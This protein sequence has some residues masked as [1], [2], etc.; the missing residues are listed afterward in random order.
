MKDDSDDL[1]LVDDEEDD[2]YSDFKYEDDEDDAYNNDD[3]VNTIPLPD[4]IVLNNTDI[5]HRQ[6]EDITR[7]S[8]ILSV[9]KAHAT[10]LLL[11]YNWSVDKLQEAWFADEEKVR[12][13]AGLLQT[14][15]SDHPVSAKVTCGI[16]FE[17]YTRGKM[18][19]VNC[20]HAF[21]KEC[22]KGYLKTS[23]Q[24]GP[25]CLTLRCPQPKCGAA[26]G[27]DMIEKLVSERYKKKYSIYLLRFY[28][29]VNQKAKWCPSPGC[30]FAIEHQIGSSNFDV[31]CTCTCNFCWN[32]SEDAHRPVDCD[33]I[34]KWTL[35][36][37]DESE[38]VTWIMAFTK[39][40]PK[41]KRPVEKNGGCMHM[42]CSAPCNNR[43]CWTCLRSYDNHTGPCNAY[44]AQ[45]ND[46]QKAKEMLDRYAH[47]YERWA[48]NKKSRQKAMEDLKNVADPSVSALSEK[49]SGSEIECKFITEAWLQIVE[50]RRVLMWTY[51]YGYYLPQE[52]KAKKTLF[53]FLQGQAETGL[54]RLHYCAE[55]E[56]RVFLESEDLDKLEFCDFKKKLASLTGVTKNYFENLVRALENG[57]VDV[58]EN[59]SKWFCEHCTFLNE[60]SATVCEMCEIRIVS[61]FQ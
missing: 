45:S 19:T 49:M 51:A 8:S 29:Q 36:N 34:A 18:H 10:I 3:A 53:E 14:P 61:G 24:D 12:K 30:D 56:I 58:D 33:T 46:V 26:V 39:P 16:C 50:C 15:I 43:F 47:Y 40:C 2:G 20:S 6:E 5:H 38:N 1:I 60:V 21:C 22:W 27:Q 35:K 31:T 28:I 42:R 41:C 37:K 48:A 4:F 55:T 54:E 9:S 32:C 11:N 44:V 7:V 59:R 13:K 25:G 57:L 52:E 23:I 17:Y